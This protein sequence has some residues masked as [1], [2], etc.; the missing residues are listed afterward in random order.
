M[1]EVNTNGKTPKAL[2][3]IKVAKYWL[4]NITDDYERYV[5]GIFDHL[6]EHYELNYS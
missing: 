4:A 1:Q 5:K 2:F 6:V 3:L